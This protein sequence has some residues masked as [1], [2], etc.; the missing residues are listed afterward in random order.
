MNETQ[1]LNA[2]CFAL[3]KACRETNAEKMTLTQENVTY[4]GENIGDWEMTIQKI[5]P[6]ETKDNE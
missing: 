3:I 2:Y 6:K 1:K 4:L 5:N